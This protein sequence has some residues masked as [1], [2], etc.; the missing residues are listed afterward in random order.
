MFNMDI[1]EW[2]F[3]MDILECS[4]RDIK[5]D[6]VND[7][8]RVVPVHCSLRLRF[9]IAGSTKECPYNSPSLQHF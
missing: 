1:L 7:T 9:C 8:H 4:K 3:L 2:T 5:E 6:S